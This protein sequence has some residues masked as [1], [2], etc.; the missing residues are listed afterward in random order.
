[1]PIK[2]S[3]WKELR[4]GK[5]RRQRNISV[6]SELRTLLRKLQNFI[7]SAKKQDAFDA[8]K[9]LVSKLDKAASNKIIHKNTASRSKSR[10]AKKI[11][12]LT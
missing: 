1:M 8:Y 5:R 6:K 11:S 3:A 2:K 7:A 9:K 12:K 10:L 4:K